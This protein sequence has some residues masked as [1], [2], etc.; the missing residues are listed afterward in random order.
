[1]TLDR[2]S[3]DLRSHLGLDP[4]PGPALTRLPAGGAIESPTIFLGAFAGGPDGAGNQLRPWVRAVL[5]SPRTW[6]DSNYPLTVNN[7][8]GAGMQSE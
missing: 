5:G 8:W 1:M 4:E 6:A 7:S 3:H 2:T